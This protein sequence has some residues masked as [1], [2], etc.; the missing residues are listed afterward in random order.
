MDASRPGALIAG[1]ESLLRHSDRA[2]SPPCEQRGPRVVEDC[3]GSIRS[4]RR[5]SVSPGAKAEQ[6]FS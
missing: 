2:W 5:S 3:C 6:S 1:A 4:W